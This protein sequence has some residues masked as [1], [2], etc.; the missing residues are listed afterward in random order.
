MNL[1][2]KT[3]EKRFAE[4]WEQIGS[5]NPLVLCKLFTPRTQWTWYA[6]EY[7]QE[8]K[9]F[10]GYVIGLEKERG[11]FALPELESLKWPYWLK[12]ERDLFFEEIFFNDLNV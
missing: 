12:I 3:L 1:M 8:A 10:Y 11:Y 7:S 6:T 5:K 4:V 2:T 9:V